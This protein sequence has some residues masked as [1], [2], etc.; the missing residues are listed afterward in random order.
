MRVQNPYEIE[1]A[2]T[3]INRGA[4]RVI[5]DVS[6]AQQDRRWQATATIL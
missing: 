5:G 6:Y 2:T 4:T 3:A 1:D